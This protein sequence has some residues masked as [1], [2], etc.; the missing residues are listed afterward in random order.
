MRAVEHFYY[1]F[2]AL[3]IFMCVET[4]GQEEA[5]EKEIKPIPAQMFFKEIQLL[6]RRHTVGKTELERE[7]SLKKL[8]EAIATQVDGQWL[9]FE[10]GISKVDWSND[11]ATLSTQA[12]L[13]PYKA[14]R[15]LP[16]NIVK[17]QPFKVPMSR[18]EA[19]ALNTKKPLV[20]RGKMKFLAGAWG[21]VARP[22]T[23]QNLFW[24]RHTDYPTV[25][26]IGT[27]ITEEY[28]LML[29]GQTIIDVQPEAAAQ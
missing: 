15:S 18:E 23:S 11:V 27:I 3:N 19:T 22:P 8:R 24:I 29:D 20:F 2:L 25:V 13:R 14:S 10:V 21:V 1:I 4:T 7:D 16:F 17:S 28:S 12:P 9:E 5:E 26:S 6:A